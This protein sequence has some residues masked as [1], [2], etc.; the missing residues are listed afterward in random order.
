MSGPQANLTEDLE[1]PSYDVEY[2]ADLA[3]LAQA[4]RVRQGLGWRPQ[5][6]VA[7]YETHHN[8]GYGNIIRE[9]WF[10]QA[11]VRYG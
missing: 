3:S 5:G 10:A 8:D 4:V 7:C 2:A 6:G 11:M 9:N 1:G